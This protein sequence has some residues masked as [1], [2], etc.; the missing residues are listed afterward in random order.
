MATAQLYQQSE[1]VRKKL[2]LWMTQKWNVAMDLFKKGEVTQIGERNFRIPATV[3]NGGRF[4]TYNPQGGDM[5][6]GTAQTGLFM[7]AP[8]F[9]LRLNFE[10]DHLSIEAT[11][12]KNTAIVNPFKEALKNAIPEMMLYRDK[13]AHCDGTAVIG[14][15]TATATVSGVTQ[16]TLDTNQGVMLMRRG[17]PIVPYDSALAA[18]LAPPLFINQ[19]NPQARTILL[20]GLVTSPNAT[21]KM[22]F[23]GVSGASPAGIN[24]TKY[25][26]NSAT[27]GTTLGITRS[28][29]NEIIANNVGTAGNLIHEHGMA[30]YH[31][32]LK[33]RGKVGENIV[34]LCPVEQQ[35]AIWMNVMSIQRIDLGE[36]RAEAVDR[37]PGLKGKKSFMW[38]EMPHMVDIH[39][40]AS[41]ID[42][43]I[44]ELFGW[45]RLKELGFFETPG[46]SG[47]D[48]RFYQLAGGSGGPAAALWFGLTVNENLYSI[49]PGAGGFISGLNLP[50]LYQ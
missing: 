18:P 31:R 37:L 12:S 32:I 15:A 25:Y 3:T 7:V 4:G 27:S 6:R 38:C 47:P 1:V 2:P 30:I 39:Q 26:N 16:Y 46:K 14:T 21:D 40:D 34:G 17:Q 42:Y 24:G 13:L 35:A 19:W 5:G 23:E 10:L 43:V 49:D 36:T 48:A 28:T 33:R 45:A 9:P 11:E 44:P 8:Y 41:R 20:S 22:C 29:E 50:A